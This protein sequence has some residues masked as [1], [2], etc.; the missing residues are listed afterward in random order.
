M[1]NISCHFKGTMKALT[2]GFEAE[3]PKTYQNCFF[4]LL[5][6]TRTPGGHFNIR[7]PQ[8]GINH[9]TSSLGS[10]VYI[11]EN[12]SNMQKGKSY[13]AGLIPLTHSWS[14]CRDALRSAKDTE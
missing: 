13:E 6:G 5:K 12:K 3:Q 9:P 8:W 7:V 1:S 2:G 4:R 14:S 10:A 11:M